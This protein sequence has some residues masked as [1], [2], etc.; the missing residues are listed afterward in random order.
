MPGRGFAL[1]GMT[2]VKSC[3]SGAVSVVSASNRTTRRARAGVVLCTTAV[4]DIA[5]TS[6][7]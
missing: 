2:V 4:S 1:P 7:A 3:W 6:W 5:A